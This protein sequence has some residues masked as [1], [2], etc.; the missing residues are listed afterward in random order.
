MQIAQS[1]IGRRE[2]NDPR[3]DGVV[4]CVARAPARDAVEPHEVVEV[5]HRA[6]LPT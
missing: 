6:V 3:Q 5:G 2:I 4:E 1:A